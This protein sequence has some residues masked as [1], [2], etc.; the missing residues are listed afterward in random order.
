MGGGYYSESLSYDRI[1][2]HKKA[3]TDIFAHHAEIKKSGRVSVHESLLPSKLNGT[4]KLIR[5]SRDSADH[6]QSNAVA[7][8]FDETGSMKSIPR[9]MV[10]KL[11]Q[12]M[13]ALIKKGYLTDPQILFGAIGDAYS[14]KAPL[15]IG[16]FESDNAAESALSNFYLEGNGG[17]QFS[18]SYELAMYFLAEYASMDCLEKRGKKGYCFIIGD[19]NIYPKV[20]KEQVE[21]LIGEPIQA[22]IPVEEVLERLRSKFEVF[23]IYPREG[24][25]YS[26][27]RGRSLGI[28]DR[29]QDLF[30]QQL[31]WLDSP[32]D[33]CEVIVATIGLNE[34]FDISKINSDL[35]DLGANSRAIVS[36][37]KSLTSFASKKVMT[38]AN[39]IEDG[40]VSVERL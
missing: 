2:S 27:E 9:K 39:G 34:G 37:N 21:R 19:E 17:G 14:D 40:S 28:H 10:E 6:P 22:D 31:I 36:I 24:S 13:G 16:Q 4:G 35:A 5:E 30:G 11:P 7:I 1:R 18:E 32:N 33:V 8:I 23:W 29:L 20:N 12:L 3:G 25:N 26:G 15:Q 38:V